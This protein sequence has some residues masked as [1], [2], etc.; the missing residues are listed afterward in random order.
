VTM[1][2]PVPLSCKVYTPPDLASAVVQALEPSPDQSWLDPCVGTGAF[3]RAL[4]ERGLKPEKITAIDL[5][6]MAESADVLATVARGVDFLSYARTCV[7]KFDRIIANPPFLSLSRAPELVRIAAADLSGLEGERVH[8]SSNL[9]YVFLCASI[10]LLRPGGCL[11]YILPASSEYADYAGPI[12]RRLPG[13]FEHFKVHRSSTPLFEQVRD[14]SVVLIGYGFERP[15]RTTARYEHDSREELV[16][17]V[18]RA[19]PLEA[20]TDGQPPAAAQVLKSISVRSDAVSLSEVVDLRLGGVTG[21]AKYFL[22]SDSR[23]CALGLPEAACIPILS[24]ASH[25]TCARVG[26]A[27]WRELK[28]GDERVWLFCPADSIVS[29]P[30]VTAYLQ[31][32]ESEGG[33][34]RGAYKVSIRKPWYRTPLPPVPDGF[35]S[36]MGAHGPWISLRKMPRLTATNTLYTV[37][38]KQR[39]TPNEM[40]AWGLSLLSSSVRDSARLTGRTYP[41]G[42][43]KFEP[44]DLLRLMVPR[45]TVRPDALSTYNKAVQLLLSRSESAAATL[46]DTWLSIRTI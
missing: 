6:P 26:A 30:A 21:H 8:G 42:L 15:H 44:G 2:C 10:R 31:L 7:Q 32:A 38:F 34:S 43:T 29:D 36:G 46:A 37:Y 27:E 12:R 14:G 24:R 33:C 5:S 45:P 23:R 20:K 40:A 4:S 19:T 22:L 13:M 9:W 39:L 1:S 25:L 41:D 28:E 3:P 17:A 11:A 18:G 35:I 16:A